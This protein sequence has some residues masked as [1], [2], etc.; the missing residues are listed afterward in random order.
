MR[1]SIIMYYHT[2]SL[3]PFLKMFFIVLLLIISTSTNNINA[4]YDEA[5]YMSD[6]L[7]SLSHTPSSWSNKI[8]HC[9]W[10]GIT[11]NST[12]QA[13]TSI[14][15]PS[16]SLTGTLPSNIET[17]TNLTH[18]DLHNN[19]LNGPLPDFT[20]LALLQTISLGHNNFTSLPEDN[21]RYFTELRTLNL[22]NNLNLSQWGFPMNYFDYSSPLYSIDFE[23]TNMIG[24]FSDPDIFD[25]FPNLH[26]FI[27]SH[28]KMEGFLPPSLGKS[29]IRYLRLNNQ[30]GRAFSGTIDIISKMR[31]LSQAWLHHNNF[32]GHIPNMSN[33]INLFDLQLQSNS[34][35][36]LVPPSLFSLTSLNIISLEENRL[37][38]PLPEFRKGVN[39]TFEHNNFCR[40]DVG[41]CD[42]Q[43]MILYE[44]IDALGSPV[45][46]ATQGNNAC[47]GGTWIKLM[48]DRV[49]IKCERG[50]IVSFKICYVNG[51]HDSGSGTISPKFSN[52]TSLVNLTLVGNNLTGPIPHS[53]TTLHHLQLLDVSDNNLS[54]TIPKFPYEI[55]LNITGNNLLRQN[56]SRQGRGENATTPGDDQTGGSS[57]AANLRPFWI[58][59]AFGVGFVILI[60]LIICK[61]KRYHILV[62]RWV[63]KKTIKSIDNNVED[64]IKSYNLSVPIKQYRYSEVKRMTNSFRDKLGQGGYGVVYKASL[65]DGR[66]VAVKVINESKGNGEEFIN[67]VDS[68]SRTSHVNIVSLLGFCYENKRALIYE[69][70][71]KG[72]LDKFILKGG[73]P[74]AICSLD[75][76]T[77]YKI[78]IG[79]ARGLE[80]LHQGC[81]SRIL[82]LDIKPQNILLDED[83]CP[84][85]SDFGLAKICKRNNSIVSMLGT[86]GTVGYIAPEV[87]NRMFGG[88]S[89]KSDVYSYGML[90]LEMIGGRKNYDTGGSCTSEMYFP[91]WIY[92]DLEQGNNLESGLA[93]S[94]EE[95]DMVRKITMVSL[96]CIQT[97]PSDRPSMSR[98]IEMLQGPLL[99]MSYPPKPFLYS[100][101]MPPLQTSHVSSSNLQETNSES[102]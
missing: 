29:A 73:F 66:Q 25:S 55:K 52:L 34:L 50:K 97:N 45:F 77:M 20:N 42:S 101:E 56:M 53:L 54:G 48:P 85:I 16:N 33:C 1:G 36:G 99:S 38:G 84:K 32:K 65:P 98:V 93:N 6:L 3:L 27:I 92:K 51:I 7:Q 17:L 91:D 70:M 49:Q 76:N 59:G 80:Y 14:I 67:E 43:I 79:I 30:R 8:H 10:K 44:I 35:D 24:S 23:A 62:K 74:Y 94:E 72:S 63:I 31:N 69:Y 19:S 90:I 60:V 75:W 96:W 82:H 88:V 40:S 46:L 68:I 15:L 9:K 81:I 100:P 22:S 78:A 2:V 86:R 37:Q 57:K 11:C 39:A 102:Q 21:L 61:R 58:A 83:F 71:S 89:H 26:T 4:E 41:P 47:T 64:F 12:T 95:N 28:N 87:F 5:N 13:V 18:I